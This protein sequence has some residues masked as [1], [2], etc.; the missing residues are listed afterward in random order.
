M[1]NNVANQNLLVG[2]TLGGGVGLGHG[3]GHSL[4]LGHNLG[5]SILSSRLGVGLGSGLYNPYVNPLLAPPS[6][7]LSLAR[8]IISGKLWLW[9]LLYFIFHYLKKIRN[10]NFCIFTIF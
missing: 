9:Y 7:N 5:H 8:S 6:P 2:S 10:S 1:A 3:L 4:G